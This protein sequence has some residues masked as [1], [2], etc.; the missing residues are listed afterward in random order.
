[1]QCCHLRKAYE[2][3]WFQ[4]FKIK[5]WDLIESYRMIGLYNRKEFLNFDGSMQSSKSAMIIFHFEL[6]MMGKI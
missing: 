5:V 1:M 2:G 3:L 6:R 4:L